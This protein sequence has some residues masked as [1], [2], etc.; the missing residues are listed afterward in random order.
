MKLNKIIYFF[1][2][3]FTIIFN[4]VS[5]N[6]ENN[7]V[8]E[9]KYKIYYLNSDGTEV[10]TI[11][12]RPVGTKT[13][14]L[15]DE[16]INELYKT[17]NVSNIKRAIPENLSIN[18]YEIGNN[19]DMI[20][21][22]DSE[23]YNITG[24]NEILL[25]YII[26]QTFCQIDGINSVEFKVNGNTLIDAYERAVGAMTPESFVDITGDNDKTFEKTT[27]KLYFASKDGTELIPIN[28]EIYYDITI[29]I[30]ELVIKELIKGPKEDSNFNYTV[31]KDTKLLKITTKDGICYLDFNEKFL[32]KNSNVT[33]DV[34]IYSVVNSLVELSNINKVQF[35][36]NGDQQKTYRDGITFTNL[37]ERNL[38][39]VATKE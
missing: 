15:V 4:F 23:Y 21:Y 9:E 12:Y 25:R 16:F 24:V 18:S 29:P 11:G 33:D 3:F 20:F 38:D 1:M 6:K 34:L 8:S 5:C 32:V 37:F 28:R 14:E 22:F 35:S 2:F 19:G 10:K 27:I 13:K 39:I 17:P 31:P 7:N 26:V 30:E 36:I